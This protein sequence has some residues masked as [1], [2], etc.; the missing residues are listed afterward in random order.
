M[1]SNNIYEKEGMGMF[2]YFNKTKQ[3]LKNGLKLK[4]IQ[5]SHEQKSLYDLV[6]RQDLIIKSGLSWNL[7]GIPDWVMNL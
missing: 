5:S 7:L 1:E 6:L 3:K 4:P 2:V